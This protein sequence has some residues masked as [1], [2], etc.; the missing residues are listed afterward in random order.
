MGPLKVSA[1]DYRV[2]SVSLVCMEMFLSEDSMK[3]GKMDLYFCLITAQTP[4]S[5]LLFIK[6]MLHFERASVV[7]VLHSKDQQLWGPAIS[8][9]F[10]S[11]V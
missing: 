10:F 7:F 9:A 2:T 3:K 8:T 4:D 5:L 11:F 6:V 1:S